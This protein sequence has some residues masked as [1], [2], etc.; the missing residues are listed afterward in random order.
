MGFIEELT[1][2]FATHHTIR[3]FVKTMILAALG[4]VVAQQASLVAV[5]PDWAMVPATALLVALAN[6]L[7]YNP[8]LPV[9]GS[10]GGNVSKVSK[11]G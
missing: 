3:K 11:S 1:E 5:L 2:W 8:V 10:K 7:E 6:W 9:V 4:F